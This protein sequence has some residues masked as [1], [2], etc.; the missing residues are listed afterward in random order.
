MNRYFL[1]RQSV[2]TKHEIFFLRK[3]SHYHSKY[4]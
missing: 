2:F 4:V 3:E 1:Q